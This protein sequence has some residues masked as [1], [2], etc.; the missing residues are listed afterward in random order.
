MG[1][2]DYTVP[3]VPLHG[4]F[5]HK[6][7]K[8][9]KAAP[10]PAPFEPEWEGGFDA[11]I[12]NP[13]YIRMETFK[14]L[15]GYL[16]SRYLTHAERADI[17]FYFVEAAK[18][19]VRCDGRVGF[20]LSNTFTRSESGA[21][22]REFISSRFRIETLVEFGDFLPFKGATVYPI[23][24]ILS[25][26]D[27]RGN[28]ATVDFVLQDSEPYSAQTGFLNITKIAASRFG[29]SEWTFEDEAPRHLRD[30]LLQDFPSLREVYGPVNMGIK[31]GLNEAFI[32]DGATRRKIIAKNKASTE[33]IK[34]YLGGRHLERYRAEG[35][36]Q[37]LIYTPRGI[38]MR[39]YP[40]VL[41]HLS[42]F[43]KELS[44]RATQQ[45]WFELQQSQ[46]A[47][48]KHF[49]GT[50]IIYPDMSRYPKFSLD[51]S[52]AYFSNTVYFIGSD[53]KF[54][55]GLLNSKLLWFVIRG[56]S[57]ALRGGL[58]RFRLFSGHVE[59]LPMPHHDSTRSDKAAHDRMVKLVE[60]M[61]EL[62]RQLAA[63]RTPQE[64][65]ALERQIAA[66][67]AEIDRLVYQL[68]GLTADEIKIVEGCEK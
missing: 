20:I 29:K 28:L 3:G 35:E 48:R 24:T 55:L 17:F 11:V 34:P 43:R 9:E 32:I 18:H 8:G 31:T 16:Q 65:T 2:L 6:Q 51:E 40:A 45:E 14:E 41:N 64:Q 10:L 49:D 46:E 15:K 30:R 12:G 26:R 37:F 67:D 44:G 50:K 58:W 57:N 23:I 66:A 22:L 21:A 52:G 68:Y 63:A 61:L 39:A 56:L 13:P 19:L 4:G 1:E 36:G 60:Q 47:F 7:M 38:D 27:S 62:H 42:Q 59:R 54:L 53:S 25:R 5:S 33:I